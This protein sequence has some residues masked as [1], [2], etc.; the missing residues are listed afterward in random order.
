MKALKKIIKY[1]FDPCITELRPTDTNKLSVYMYRGKVMV[2]NSEWKVE[3]TKKQSN[4]V[5]AIVFA[6]PETAITL[7]NNYYYENCN[8]FTSC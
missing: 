6:S 7:A 5:W 8:K 3:L 2:G 4:E 1:L